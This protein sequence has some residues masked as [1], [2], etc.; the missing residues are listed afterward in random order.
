MWRRG[1][2]GRV[3]GGGSVAAAWKTARWGYTGR[4]IER[5]GRAFTESTARSRLAQ[6]IDAGHAPA[7]PTRPTGRAAYPPLCRPLRGQMAGLALLK[8]FYDTPEVAEA[9]AA[10][11]ASASP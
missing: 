7:S 5:D 10:A 4:G 8:R 9:A 3:C 1:G 6:P 11:P 2:G